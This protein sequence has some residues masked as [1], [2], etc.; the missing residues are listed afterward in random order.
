ME[1]KLKERTLSSHIERALRDSTI[2][3]PTEQAYS[4]KVKEDD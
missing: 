1:S 4:L 2:H 3:T